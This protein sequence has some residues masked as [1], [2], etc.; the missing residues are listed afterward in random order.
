MTKFK[1]GLL[2]VSAFVGSTSMVLAQETPAIDVSGV[3][4]EFLG[5]FSTAAAVIGGV[6]ISAAFVALVWKW[7]KGMVFN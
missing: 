1:K 6:L 7:V 4:D 2:A 5:N 3:A